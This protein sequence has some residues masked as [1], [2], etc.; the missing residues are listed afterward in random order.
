[1]GGTFQY[2]I[3]KFSIFTLKLFFVLRNEGGQKVDEKYLLLF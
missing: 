3:F 2:S 1:M